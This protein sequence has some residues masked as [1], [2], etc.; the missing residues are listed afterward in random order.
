M[1][2]FWHDTDICTKNFMNQ[3]NIHYLH[4]TGA[5]DKQGRIW[6]GSVTSGIGQRKSPSLWVTLGR[7]HQGASVLS[8]LQVCFIVYNCF[9]PPNTWE[10]VYMGIILLVIKLLSK[11]LVTVISISVTQHRIIIVSLRIKC[12]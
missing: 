3:H 11:L 1:F 2:Q 9:Q 6:I 12:K 10:F 8:T 7:I 4:L 5:Y